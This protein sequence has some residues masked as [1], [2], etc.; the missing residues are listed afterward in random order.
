[1]LSIYHQLTAVL[2][3]FLSLVQAR[4]A[5]T[6]PTIFF[7]LFIFFYLYIFFLPRWS[8]FCLSRV[9]KFMRF[10]MKGRLWLSERLAPMLPI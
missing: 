10:K 3:T 2:N 4:P 8:C 7:Y 5:D 6:L 1:M 9:L